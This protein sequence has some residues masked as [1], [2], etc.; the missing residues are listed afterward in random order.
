MRKLLI[1]RLM[2]L[3]VSNVFFP[4]STSRWQSQTFEGKFL[5]DIIYDESGLEEYHDDKLLDLYAQIIR[6]SSKQF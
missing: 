3:A 5:R 1:E 4:K 2:L 6:Q